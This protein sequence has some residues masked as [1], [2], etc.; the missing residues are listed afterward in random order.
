MD[1]NCKDSFDR[2]IHPGDTVEVTMRIYNMNKT[3][4]QLIKVVGKVEIFEKDP[5]THLPFETP[6]CGV[7]ELDHRGGV[8][9]FVIL[10]SEDPLLQIKKITRRGKMKNG[11]PLLGNFEDIV[12]LAQNKKELLH[13]IKTEEQRRR[14]VEEGKRKEFIEDKLQQLSDIELRTLKEIVIKEM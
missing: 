12:F 1:I 10:D 14:A 4:Y 13:L 7:V 8:Y 5:R 2:S 3:D 9:Q 6:V 11:K